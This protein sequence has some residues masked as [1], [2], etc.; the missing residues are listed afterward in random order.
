MADTPTSLDWERVLAQERAAIREPDGRHDGPGRPL[1]GLAFSGGGI[2][3]ATFNLGVT[4]ALAELKLLRQFDYL[5]CVSGG[6][7]IGG[8]LSAFIHRKCD[9]RVETAEKCLQTGGTENSAIRFLRGY[10]NYLTPQASFFSADT[11]TAVATYLRNLYLNLVLLLL[12]LGGV[13]LL[14]R[15]LVWLVRWLVGWEGAHAEG[16]ARLLPL[17]GGGILCIFIAMI[18]IGLNLGSRGAFKSRPFYTRQ[19][20]VLILVVLPGL[21]SAW[22]IAYG[23]YVGAPTLEKLSPLAW[24]MWGMLVYVPPWLAGWILGHFLG[25]H[26]P[27]QARFTLVQ[28]AQMAIYALLAGALGGLLLALLAEVAHVIPRGENRYSG[29]WIASAL[30]TPLLLKFYS[31]TVVGHIGLMG[32]YFSHDSREW[33]S[34]LGGWVLL[35]S[36]VWAAVFCIV[37]I[38]PAFFRWAP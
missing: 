4:Q 16:G 15:L 25:R 37:F 18:F 19:S 29:S 17:F 8:W 1:T 13:L 27:G 7:Y 6:G 30:A 9:G 24:A 3:S 35:V 34:R 10:S 12:T 33:W 28:L 38:A 32:R 26:N 23:F 5:S 2:R 14:P 31:L 22:L 21:L 20:G 11:L 36:L